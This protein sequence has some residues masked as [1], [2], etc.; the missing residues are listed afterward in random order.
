MPSQPY[1][2][3]QRTRPSVVAVAVA[4]LACVIIYIRRSIARRKFARI[5]GCQPIAKSYSR[6]PFLGLDTIPGTVR[7][8][9]QHRILD[10]AC[11]LFRLYGNTFK[12]REFHKNAIVTME[13]E[14]I[15]TI[16]SLNFGDYGISH[17]LEAFKPLLGQGIFDTDGDHWSSSRGLIRPSFTR[18]QVAD[19]TSFESLIQDLFALLPH[20][21]H[22][23]VDL[24][25]LFFSYTIDS[26]TEFLF[27]QSAGTLKAA[28]AKHG[29]ADA[30]HHAQDAIIT[31]GLLGPF[32]MFYH[33]RKTDECN[34]ICRDFAQKFV[35]EAFAAVAAEKTHDKSAKYVFAHE[36][37]SRTT[38]KTRVLDELMNVLLAGRDTTA[39]MLS[40]L[41]FMLAKKPEIW[42]KLR[43]EVA[44]LEGRPPTYEELRGLEYVQCCL[45][46]CEYFYV[47]VHM[48][49]SYRYANCY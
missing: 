8:L 29:F 35:D 4:V 13:P 43:R 18:D 16:L 25:P 5:N 28:E 3:L 17:R 27:G 36:L 9:R 44:V 30:F 11:D 37:A 32:S 34:R 1:L 14:N 21:G 7:A 15:K 22:T 6:D 39:S 31:R 10:Q 38:D 41:F 26:A 2:D 24:Q 33:S 12:L 19:L 47:G 49:E 45:N 23:V 20:D 48:M 42:D 40:N 46:E